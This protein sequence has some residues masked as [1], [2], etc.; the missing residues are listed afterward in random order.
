V[1]LIAAGAASG[2]TYFV[3]R[4]A[5]TEKAA[6]AAP[7]FSAAQI[8]AAQTALCHTFDVSVRGENNQGGLRDQ[9]QLNIPL[10]LRSLNSAVA[11]DNAIGPATP[12]NIANA[13]R[14]Y[15]QATLDATTA[16]AGSTSAD[17]GNRLNDIANQRIDQLADAC[18][19]PH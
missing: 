11:V 14:A 4:S 10:M 16:A 18:G 2:I 1:A 3:T 12:P 6:P 19:L 5:S 9:G 13:A 15:V 17:E 8:S 7:G